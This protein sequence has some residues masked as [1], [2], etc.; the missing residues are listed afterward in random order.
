ME[1][2]AALAGR[3]NVRL[4]CYLPFYTAEQPF[5]QFRQSF[6]EQPLWREEPFPFR[7][8]SRVYD[9]VLSLM[10]MR[11]SEHAVCCSWRYCGPLPPAP[12]ETEQLPWDLT[13]DD[14]KGLKVNFS[15]S[16]IY[17][18][19]FTTCVGILS[20]ELSVERASLG[21]SLERLTLFQN[22]IKH[23]GGWNKERVTCRNKPDRP[24]YLGNTFSRILQGT[25][26]SI[27]FF[28]ADKEGSRPDQALLYSYLMYKDAGELELRQMACRMA[29][30]DAP[31]YMPSETML[32][33]CRSLFDGVYYYCTLEGCAFAVRYAEGSHSS[34]IRDP[35]TIRQTFAFYHFLCLYQH[36]SLIFYTMKVAKEL[37]SDTGIYLSDSSCA[38]RMEQLIVDINTFLMKSDLATV[39]HLQNHNRFYA[40]CR[41]ALNIEADKQSLRS[42]FEYLENIQSGIRRSEREEIR[43][44]EKE[45]AE[46]RRQEEE[47][48]EKKRD[49]RLNA[50]LFLI[51]VF[52]VIGDGYASVERMAEIFKRMTSGILSIQDIVFLVLF[53]FILGFL[54]WPLVKKLRKRRKKGAEDQK[55]P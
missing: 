40:D 43:Q 28:K 23:I 53:V 8:D 45:E 49:G 54:C 34:Y 52:T 48:Q 38:E 13:F 4:R 31:D 44:R 17:A 41:R 27:R 39:S 1:T 22:A 3:G 46:K 11:P 21:D 32:A 9:H 37:P 26:R 47:E 19:V 35:E 30:G 10:N 36:Y 7:D 29:R 51:A 16:S 42:G 55:R 15:I 50:T 18:H 2:G 24:V 25:N 33:S 6:R 12:G 14:R 5:A 20:Y